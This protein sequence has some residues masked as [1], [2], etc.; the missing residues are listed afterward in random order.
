[1]LEP[2]IKKHP[3]EVFGHVYIDRSKSAKDA[4][5]NQYCPYLKNECNKPR[6]SEPSIK[7]GICSVGYKGDFLE[8]HH[9]IIICP[10]RFIDDTVFNT[11]KKYYLPQNTYIK[12][13][14]EVGIG[15]GGNVDYVAT[16]FDKTSNKISD[17]LCV[18]FQAAGTTG[19]PYPAVQELIKYGDFQKTDYNYGINWANEFM[20]T[21]MQQVYKKS[22][23]I[24]FWKKKI[25][26]VIQD[27]AM[28]Y[29]HSAVDTS[30]IRP[31]N[32]IDEIHF[33]TF[34]LKWF[35]NCWKLEYDNSYSTNI[36]GINKILGGAKE[37]NYL[38]VDNFIDNIYNKG[39][40]DGECK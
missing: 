28:E 40:R 35:T 5:K 11:I 37:A 30:S 18:E 34:R 17:F 12:W 36:E 38:S 10:N 15:V 7:V 9:P 31:A 6:K 13:V 8:K 21:M 23:I 26:F 2:S 39:K 25:I 14:S 19:T 22:K 32:D 20:K 33:L 1:M 29:L 24:T 16:I 27:T 3:T 4:L